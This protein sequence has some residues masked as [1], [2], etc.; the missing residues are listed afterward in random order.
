MPILLLIILIIVVMFSP[1]VIIFMLSPY[2]LI[3]IGPAL[4]VAG[5]WAIF[6]GPAY[7]SHWIDRSGF[8]N[9][10]NR[11]IILI[12]FSAPI[13]ILVGLPLLAFLLG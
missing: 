13:L 6:A 2:G 1:G 3:L 7:L 4:F 8:D 11:T 5:C 10:S 12:A 9:I